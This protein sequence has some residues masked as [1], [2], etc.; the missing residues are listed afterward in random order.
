MTDR[1]HVVPVEGH[2]HGELHIRTGD[3]IR[4]LSPVVLRPGG[5][6]WSYAIVLWVRA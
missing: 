5:V 1:E 2:D 6:S 3:A 4:I